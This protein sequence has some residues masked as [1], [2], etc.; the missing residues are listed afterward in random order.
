MHYICGVK[1]QEKRVFERCEFLLGEGNSIII[2]V[3]TELPEADTYTVSV[4]DEHMKFMA[5]YDDVAQM[6]YPG[7]EIFK[8]IANNTQIGLVEYP[9][10]GSDFPTDITKLAYVEVMRAH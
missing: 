10:D 2:V 8:R 6:D 5:D 7:G 1:V 3:P 9:A 4:T